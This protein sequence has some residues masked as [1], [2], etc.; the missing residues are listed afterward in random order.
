QSWPK[1][2][3]GPALPDLARRVHDELPRFDD[4]DMAMRPDMDLVPLDE[5]RG[6]RLELNLFPLDSLRGQV[7][8]DPE[9]AARGLHP[10]LLRFDRW[11]LGRAAEIDLNFLRRQPAIDANGSARSEFLDLDPAL[12]RQGAARGNLLRLDGAV[13]LKRAARLDPV[14]VNGAHGLANDVGCVF[15]VAGSL[16]RRLSHDGPDRLTDVRHRGLGCFRLLRLRVVAGLDLQVR[17]L[18]DLAAREPFLEL[19]ED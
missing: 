18:V 5:R 6:R 2:R 7:A 14:E 13:D 9:E 8:A 19:A 16:R 17:L 11:N 10:N 1:S 15:R 12:D 3:R 4:V